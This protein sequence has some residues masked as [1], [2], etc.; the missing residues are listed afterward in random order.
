M[1]MHPL[2]EYN[3][4]FFVIAQ[5][6]KPHSMIAQTVKNNFKTTSPN[7]II[8]IT[9]I[10]NKIAENKDDFTLPC[11]AK[12]NCN[13]QTMIPIITNIL[14]TIFTSIIQSYKNWLYL[15]FKTYY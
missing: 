12:E 11:L 3:F 15:Q 8:K 5:K 7:K 13:I 14:A 10:L 1:L 2:I 9:I 6:D 4:Y